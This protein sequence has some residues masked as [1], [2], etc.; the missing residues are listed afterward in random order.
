M[1]KPIA[2]HAFNFILKMTQNK[3]SHVFESTGA[4]SIKGDCV[5]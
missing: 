4:Q 2:F 1:Y 5:G 3:L